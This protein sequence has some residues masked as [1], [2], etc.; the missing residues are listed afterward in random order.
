MSNLLS[1]GASGLNAAQVAL[2]TV[3]NNISNVNTPGYSRQSVVQNESI[4]PNGGRYTIGSGVDVDSIQRAYS[5][6]LTSAVWSSNSSLQRATTYNNLTTT[7]NSMLSASG[8]LQSSLDSFYGA[9]DTVA[10]T[11][12]VASSRQSLLG[13]AGSMVTTFNTLA[14][15][16]TAQQGQVNSQIST[17]VDG[18]N[19]VSKSIADL[20]A[21]IR[22]AGNNV[23]N[24]LLDQRDTMI[25]TLS[26][27]V[28]VSTYQQTDGTIS[29]YA[30]SGQALVSG[31]KSFALSTGKDAYD[32]SRTSVL[33][34]TGTDITT[35]I[36]GGTLGALLDYRSNVLDSVQNQLGQA[37]VAL[38]T[39]V[40]TQQSKGLDLNGNQGGPMFSVPAPAVMGNTNNKGTAS[41]SASITDVSQLTTSDYVL[42]Y[43][44]SNWNLATTSGQSVPMTTNPD[45]S[46][47]AN[48]L[49]FNLS[50]TAQKGDSF[51]IQPTRAAASGLTLT[52]TDP[53]GIA[54]AAA[55]TSK[56]ATANT[57]TGSIGAVTVDDP[58]N[59]AL[60]SNA[61]LSFPTAGTYQVTDSSGNVL[62]SGSYAPGQT[63][64]ANGW[65]VTPSGTPAA[66][67]SFTI[68]INSNGLNDTSN[69]LAL[70]S[71]A[72]KG[73]LNGGKQSVIDSY[74]T[75]T[76]NIGT[77]G[78]QAQTNL[79]TQTSL[80]NQAMSAQQ[81]VSG[82]NL[83]E[84]AASLVRFQQAYQASAQVISTSQTIFSSLISA[85][86]G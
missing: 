4:S 32:A 85:I 77:V 39:S 33:D 73:V 8:N 56:A 42:S 29:V 53:N 25:Q 81:S 30:S 16:F 7:L 34:T 22:Q 40:N 41:V 74:G 28:G 76:T 58:T 67:D 15:Q 86:N 31:D 43:D 6:F 12:G 21:K 54:A 70:A 75:L 14:Q 55:L 36:S 13:S 80:H 11:P 62:G 68:G 5:D 66:N 46:Y 79:T 38:A 64:S 72:D 84:E 2:T 82:V 57:G 3:G 50:G 60:L 23:P 44:G 71:L 26:G 37:A 35:K 59:A 47:S 10:N 48:G 9:F 78:S 69:A 24:D 45:G 51:Q 1:I 18:I 49:T 61:T 83:D 17:T 63:I 52:M 19:S 65:S 20:N 27:Y